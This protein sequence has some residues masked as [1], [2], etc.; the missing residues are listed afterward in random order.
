MCVYNVYKE[1]RKC[2]YKTR[3]NITFPKQ[4]PVESCVRPTAPSVLL[5]QTLALESNGFLST[6][7]P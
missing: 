4:Q 1:C 5:R 7:T 2:M 6:P 3:V